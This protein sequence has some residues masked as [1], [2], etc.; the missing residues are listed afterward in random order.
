MIHE[1]VV[2]AGQACSRG[3][4]VSAGFAGDVRVRMLRESPAGP[5]SGELA[6]SPRVVRGIKLAAAPV[7][8]LG[9]SASGAW[10]GPAGPGGPVVSARS[11]TRPAAGGPKS[12]SNRYPTL[13]SPGLDATPPC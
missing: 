3:Q 9:Y 6:P 8:A 4:G 10:L 1:G 5:F 2:C 11:V 13:S 12:K 7:D